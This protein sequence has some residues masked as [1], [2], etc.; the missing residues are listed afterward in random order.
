MLGAMKPGPFALFIVIP[1]RVF[2]LPPE[3]KAQRGCSINPL[4]E[5]TTKDGF[6]QLKLEKI[7][8]TRMNAN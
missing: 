2:F 3:M 7:F 8:G 6:Y 5:K 1:E 4:V